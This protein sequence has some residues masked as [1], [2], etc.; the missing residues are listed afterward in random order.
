MLNFRKEPHFPYKSSFAGYY[1][2]KS[3]S[4]KEFV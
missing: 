2:T 1:T 3:P 4:S